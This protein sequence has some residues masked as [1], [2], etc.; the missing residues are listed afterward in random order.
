MIKLQ[1]PTWIN[2]TFMR[3]SRKEVQWLLKTY[4]IYIHILR[5]KCYGAATTTVYIDFVSYASRFV[6]ISIFNIVL[7]FTTLEYKNVVLMG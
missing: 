5:K 3:T 4:V 7:C 1:I 2:H 6:N